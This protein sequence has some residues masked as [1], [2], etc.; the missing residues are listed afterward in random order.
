MVKNNTLLHTTMQ[1]KNSVRTPLKGILLLMIFFGIFCS[2]GLTPLVRAEE[3]QVSAGA[4]KLTPEE[5]EARLKKKYRRSKLTYDLSEG[6]SDKR[7]MVLAAGEDKIVDLDF[8]C[9]KCLDGQCNQVIV[10]N[11]TIVGKSHVNIGD[12]SQV[13]FRPLKAGTTTVT[14]R[15]ND[16]IMRLIFHVRV[17]D[18]DLLRLARDLRHL[19]R[20][21]EGVDIKIVG[22]KIIIEG[23][24]LV[25]A[26][27]GRLLT[28]I[29]DD[30]YAKYV[31]NLAVVS[32]ISMQVVAKRIQDDVAAFAPNVKT[33]VVNG[34]IFLE[35]NV[36]SFD[37]A[38]RAE[39]IAAIY[40]PIRPKEQIITASKGEAEVIQNRFLIYNFIVVNPP[41]KKKMEKLVRV[42][43]HF[44][45]LY[46]DYNKLFGFK[47]QPTITP[48]SDQ[49]NIGTTQEGAVGGGSGASFSA[50]IASLIPKLQS[51]QNAGYAR[52]LKTGTVITR[53][54]EAAQ[55]NETT[56]VPYT[57]SA[58][59]GQVGSGSSK[60][61]LHVAVTP[62]VLDNNEDVQMKVVLSQS[63]FVG[64]PQ[65]GRPTMT[66]KHDV[67]SQIYVRNR[68]SGAIAAFNSADVG[69]AFNRD[70][71][72]P[73]T[74]DAGQGTD[75]L[76]NLMR[77]KAY[78]KKRSQYVIF[79]TPEIID[80]ISEGTADLKKNFRIK[81]Q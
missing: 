56:E 33:R 42:T 34:I 63:S 77:S 60:A 14:F 30:T 68:E 51:A 62:L 8:P 80:N 4:K 66:T 49:I 39:K 65:A 57:T 31:L 78:W 50:T 76:F 6:T 16:G 10:A 12:K 70:D 32:P 48:N 22:P 74:F 54:G 13:V 1:M 45:E 24:V 53:S 21:I 67:A 79:L 23:E 17:T 19:L 75:A 35:G 20:D 40:L 37:H 26:D 58:G 7:D 46:K 52:V 73:M 5:E 72:K 71:P 69:T 41:P 29:Q 18:S 81:V 3:S 15:D 36:D 27:Y 55:I 9:C 47:W 28:V 11:P 2:I 61:E 64:T 44:V 59:N 43:A 25:P 38:R